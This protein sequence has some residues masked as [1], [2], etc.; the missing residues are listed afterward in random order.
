MIKDSVHSTSGFSGAGHFTEP[1]V[2]TASN[3]PHSEKHLL[4]KVLLAVRISKRFLLWIYFNVDTELPTL[5]AQESPPYVC[6][7]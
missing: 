4:P 5:L 6:E 7:V 3:T 2:T 1:P